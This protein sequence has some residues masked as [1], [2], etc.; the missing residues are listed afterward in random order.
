MNK[1]QI[2]S[3]DFFLSIGLFFI[4][5]GILVAIIDYVGTQTRSSQE[6]G[7]MYTV[8]N[9]VSDLLLNT[10]GSPKDWNNS[11]ARSVGLASG[12]L[13]NQSKILQFVNMNYNTTK[14]TMKIKQ[15][16]IRVTFNRISGTAMNINGTELI[17]GPEPAPRSHAVKLQRSRV[18][19]DENNNKSIVIID[20][21]LWKR[22]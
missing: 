21:I 22:L 16:E 14:S 17:T 6:E 5:L 10:E 15:Y 4:V 1:G 20:F 19:A 8:A 12:E 7:F 2:V 13:L 9:A 11:S 18:M 3:T